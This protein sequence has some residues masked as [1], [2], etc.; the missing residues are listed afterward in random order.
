M[1]LH[2]SRGSGIL[3]MCQDG[4]SLLSATCCKEPAVGVVI[5][6]LGCF[7][8]LVLNISYAYKKKHR[9]LRVYRTFNADLIWI[10]FRKLQQLCVRKKHLTC[11]FSLYYP[12]RTPTNGKKEEKKSHPYYV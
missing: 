1:K 7:L 6:R 10:Q 2:N 8:P 5:F 11:K 12:A 4:L 9:S 3:H